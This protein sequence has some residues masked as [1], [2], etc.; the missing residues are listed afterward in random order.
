MTSQE[1]PDSYAPKFP[2]KCCKNVATDGTYQSCD[3]EA[4][5]FYLH[6]GDICAY[7]KE[8]HFVCG[9]K[10]TKEEWERLELR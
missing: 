7:C 9:I 6:S 4:E 3:K 1:K 5:F 8:C 2:T 10:I